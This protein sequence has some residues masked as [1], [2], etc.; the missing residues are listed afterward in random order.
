IDNTALIATDGTA[1]TGI[2]DQTSFNFTTMGLPYLT[3]SSPPDNTTGMSVAT[4]S[5]KL[6]FNEAISSNTGNIKVIE[7]L[8]G[9][10]FE[11][12]DVTGSK[13]TGWGTSVITL[14]FSKNFSASSN[15]HVLID[16]TAIKNSGSAFYGGISDQTT[17]NFTTSDEGIVTLIASN[18]IDDAQ[19]VSVNNRKLI[20]TFSHNLVV[21]SGLIKLF[22]KADEKLIY[23]ADVNSDDV[24]VKNAT[25]TV[26]WPDWL[27]PN[28]EYYINI[29]ATT[30]TNSDE[31]KF[32]GIKNQTTLNFRTSSR[33]SSPWDDP[34]IA[35]M[36][37]AQTELVDRR[38]YESIRPILDRLEWFRAHRKERHRSVHKVKVDIVQPEWQLLNDN[39]AIDALSLIENEF[40]DVIRGN[41]EVESTE[42]LGDWAMWTAGDI[43]V[44]KVGQQRHSSFKHFHSEG[45]TLGFDKKLDSSRLIGL[46]LRGANNNTEIG[47]QGTHIDSVDYGIAFYKTW[48]FSD[49]YFIDFILGGN[50]F[51]LKTH[52]EIGFGNPIL[53]ERKAYQGY[54]SLSIHKEFKTNFR[55][56]FL[57]PYSRVD[58]GYTNLRPFEETGGN[59]AI[60][61]KEQHIRHARANLGLHLDY[62]F[63]NGNADIRPYSRVEYSLDMSNSSVVSAS[64]VIAPET[65]FHS[66]IHNLRASNW[67]Y[68]LGL[69][70]K[71]LTGSIGA[72]YERI[73]ESEDRNDHQVS[74]KSDNIRF[75]LIFQF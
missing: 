7:T 69:D 46:A 1:Y 70:I 38:L 25:V 56:L 73:E 49:K 15:Y 18:P 36:V 26:T 14:A 17:L 53:G 48:T 40:F 57:T 41:I 42:S 19:D 54:Q 34:D 44:G 45:M 27:R 33:I 66:K 32:A 65:L 67:K 72:S 68:G 31:Q 3:S 4:E 63:T 55:T 29:D 11:S 39:P 43:V 64:Y 52:R 51:N 71:F 74:R 13:I 75:K 28:T 30:F 60:S 21:G 5:L 8:S 62:L 35:G 47:V 58:V 20:L 9:E 37:E 12:F 6:T 2:S 10:T 22:S 50:Q 24:L 16:S 61:F 23:S 59:A